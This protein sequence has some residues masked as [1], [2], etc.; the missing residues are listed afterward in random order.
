MSN[1][2]LQNKIKPK[3]KKVVTIQDM[4]EARIIKKNLVYIIGLSQKVANRELLMKY[5][6]LAQYGKIIKIVVN[7]NKAYNA[8]NPKGPSYSA[9]VTYAKSSDASIAILSIDSCVV[10]EHLVRA[11]FGTTK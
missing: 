1:L 4:L 2:T 10:D 5:E 9:Y 3:T 6:Y 11:S 8:N 7:K